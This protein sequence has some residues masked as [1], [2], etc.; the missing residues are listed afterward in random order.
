MN[1]TD[2]QSPEVLTEAE[3]AKIR[4]EETF[5]FEVR[6]QLETKTKPAKSRKERI[7]SALNSS[8]VLWILSSVVL[9]SLTAGYTVYKN[10]HTRVEEKIKLENKLN[11]EISYRIYQALA[12][13]KS[14]EE[15]LKSGYPYKPADY[16][17][18]T[19][20]YL[21]NR[22]VRNDVNQV[23][24]EFFVFLD[25][26]DRNFRSL[27]TELYDTVDPTEKAELQEVTRTYEK[28]ADK[29]SEAALNSEKLDAKDSL[30]AITDIRQMINTHILK[31]R[32]R[33]DELY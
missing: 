12:G 15:R 10:R 25:Y 14:D 3:K 17:S 29:G 5:C 11:T 2:R 22:F 4:A 31:K 6:R 20:Y 33:K 9:S 24:P 27:L 7:W 16:Y 18:T 26:K 30:N 32:W 8:F 28:I 23:Y 21:N 13:L 1:N 19:T